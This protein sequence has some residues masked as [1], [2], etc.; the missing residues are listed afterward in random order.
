[1]LMTVQ[2]CTFDQSYLERLRNGDVLTQ[3]H[4]AEYF[5]RLIRLKL[6]SRLASRSEID[7][8]LQE[9]FLRVWV[10]LLRV[11]GIR[12]PE[13]FGAFVSSVC[14]NVLRER[15]RKPHED[16]AEEGLADSLRESGFGV[17]D[18]LAVQELQLRVGRI[19]AK[20]PANQQ[21]LVR[22]AFWEDR[23]RDDLCRDMDITRQYL[24]VLL[25]RAKRQF[26]QLYL[27]EV[28]SAARYLTKHA[29]F[30]SARVFQPAMDQKSFGNTT[31]YPIRSLTYER[32]ERTASITRRS[33]VESEQQAHV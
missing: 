11:D 6:A 29:Q 25:H 5:G 18:R 8:V 30:P 15:R 24:R 7:D 22:Q 3:R 10:A 20:L 28:R 12:K 32:N 4:F 9:T 17:V 16:Q 27:Q 2:F 31:F 21:A 14:S 19:L 23:D 33:K 13:R 26:R 1:M